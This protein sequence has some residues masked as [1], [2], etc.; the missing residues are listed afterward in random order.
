MKYFTFIEKKLVPINAE[1]IDEAYR[2]AITALL[3]H[4]QENNMPVLTDSSVCVFQAEEA[5][6]ESLSRDEENTELLESLLKID[7]VQQILHK[8]FPFGGYST[9]D[10]VRVINQNLI[11]RLNFRIIKTK[12]ENLLGIG[13]DEFD[14]ITDN[15]LDAATNMIWGKVPNVDLIVVGMNKSNEKYNASIIVNGISFTAYS[16]ISLI[17]ALT[18]TL[19]KVKI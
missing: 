8:D 14:S 19:Y 9:M 3:L 5:I 7:E 17:D 15:Y 2:Y 10:E 16:K 6:I 4:I 11:N 1:S 12:I 18:N 13:I